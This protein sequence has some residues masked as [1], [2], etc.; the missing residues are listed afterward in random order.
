M[1]PRQNKKRNMTRETSETK[2]Y[3]T[4]GENKVKDERRN[5]NRIDKREKK[6]NRR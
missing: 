1:N 3:L 4:N 2:T 6:S 5:M